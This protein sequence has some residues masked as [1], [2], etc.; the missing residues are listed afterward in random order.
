VDLTHL[1]NSSTT[2]YTILAPPDDVLNVFE[3]GDLPERGTE[4]LKRLLQY[5]FIPGWWTPTKLKDGMLLETA[6]EDVGL[7]GGRQVL[8]VDVSDDLKPE[9]NRHV[10]FGGAG[11]IGDPS[12]SQSYFLIG[13][14]DQFLVEINNTLIYFVS[15]PLVPP[16]DALQTALPQLDLSSFL[17]AIF[18]TSLADLLKTTPRTTLLI[19]RN[20]AFK[21]LGLL[22]S[23]HLLAASSKSDLESVILH[24]VI[25]G[26]EYSQ[27]LQNG[28]QH[29]FPTLESSDIK[30]E[31][32]ANG[33]I[34]VGASGGW[35]GMKSGL[36]TRNMLTQT[37]VVHEL[38]DLM[39]PRS[40][41][42]TVG[43]LMKAAK[44]TT[45]ASMVAKVGM[46]WLLNGTAPPEGSEWADEGL[47][48]TG[49]TLLCPRDD[50]FK[51]FDLT[52]L[53][54]DVDSLQAIVRQHLIPTPPQT[55]TDALDVLY[56][57]RPLPLDNSATYSTLL[58]PAS[59]YGD[60]I[61]RQL[62]EK[63]ADGY[64]VGIKGARG[65]DG[66]ADW[67]RVLS[68]GRS[69]T[70]GGAGGVIQIDRLLVPYYP[71]WWIE[72]GGPAVVGVGGIVAIW[73]FFYMVRII[74]RR[75]TTEATY[76]PVGGFGRDD[77][78]V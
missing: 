17:A 4:E 46:D 9:G 52:K 40:V 28:S 53:F 73:A 54:A 59:A 36:Y 7:D 68:W 42:L 34:L 75:D 69:T 16:S 22:V 48:G 50:A 27:S 13:V 78:D 15:R 18:S 70:G 51:N 33:S 61:F 65:T 23:E 2:K 31:R 38:S 67:A 58:S 6:L 3:G 56:N 1:I 35:P 41:D 19:P 12:G 74:W 10:R 71:P 39:I 11:T 49:W 8:D 43:K 14:T 77:D 60:I 20:A 62:E 32:P 25:D 72:Y 47:S 26:V 55:A 37:G 24:H 29:T 76:E 57:N 66:K 21:R 63:N 5:H 30:I 45:M 64:V 44:G